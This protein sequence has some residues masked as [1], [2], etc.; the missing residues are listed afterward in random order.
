[1]TD[2]PPD[3]QALHRRLLLARSGE[4]RFRM[5]VSMARTARAL[6]WASLP[7]DL[8]EAQRRE[9]F[10][11]RFYGNDLDAGQRAEVGA[12]ASG[13][14]DASSETDALN[15][16]V[17]RLRH[18]LGQDLAFVVLFGSRAR[19]DWRP[20]SDYDVLI[21]LDRED[22]RRLI[23]RM[24]EFEGG[25]GLSVEVFPYARSEWE[26]MFRADHPLLLEA[27]ADGIILYDRGSFAGMRAA[28]E[29]WC[30]EGRLVRQPRGWTIT[31][32]VS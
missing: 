4:E 16:Y 18:R 14:I 6:V 3:V 13:Q 30:R 21:G 26:A 27:L 17:N 28:F 1:M 8:P 2:T 20:G 5:A 22:P 24:A 12:R 31:E 10:L 23:D 9:A 19:G 7:A 25:P 11:A 15:A 29:R 32:P